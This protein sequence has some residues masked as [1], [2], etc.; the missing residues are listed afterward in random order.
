MTHQNS[1]SKPHSDALIQMPWER[2]Y[3]YTRIVRRGAHVFVSGTTC[4]NEEGQALHHD[5]LHA[6]TMFIYGRIEVALQSVGASMC[7][8]VR[9][10]AFVTN[11]S[12]HALYGKAHHHW[13]S[14][15]PPVATLVEVSGLIDP[16]HL[17]EIEVDAIIDP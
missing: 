5:D 1:A 8:V 11:I 3:G 15:H 14:T 7:D 2:A 17:V 4:S 13:F 6:Q 10:R 12:N 16:N 9:T